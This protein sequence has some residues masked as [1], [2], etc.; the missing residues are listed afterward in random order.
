[1]LQNL[2]PMVENQIVCTEMNMKVN[3]VYFCSYDGLILYYLFL[4][5]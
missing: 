1:M 2:Q 4:S 5:W 3:I